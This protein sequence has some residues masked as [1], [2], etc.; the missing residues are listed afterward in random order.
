MKYE[1]NGNKIPVSEMVEM[2]QTGKR[3]PSSTQESVPRERTP[4][5]LFGV[6][7]IGLILIHTGT[8]TLPTV[9]THAV[10]YRTYPTVLLNHAETPTCTFYFPK[11]RT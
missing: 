4:F 5:F 11:I 8:G 6:Q 1:G 10:F 7:R 3:W 2:R 9:H